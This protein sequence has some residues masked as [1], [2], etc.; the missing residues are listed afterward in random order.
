MRP[1]VCL[2][3]LCT[4]LLATSC[5]KTSAPSGPHA[6][7]SDDECVVSCDHVGDCCHN[8]YCESAQH[9]DDA[10]EARTENEKHCT[11][12]DRKH[13]PVIGA[14]MQPTYS[15]A[16]HCRDSGCVA[17]QVPLADAGR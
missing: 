1:L 15:I 16:L 8:P 10:N 12:D 17:D 5:K 7:K 13:C 2:V 4:L 9:R 6:C 3:L 14:R 11:A